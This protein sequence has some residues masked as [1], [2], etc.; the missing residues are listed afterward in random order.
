VCARAQEYQVEGDAAFH[1]LACTWTA[2]TFERAVVFARLLLA[3]LRDVRI[4]NFKP[5]FGSEG[6]TPTKMSYQFVSSDACPNSAPFFGLM[7]VASALVF[8]SALPNRCTPLLI[9]RC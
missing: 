3:T 9:L 5:S 8:A 2:H 1:H 7:G 6:P 4:R